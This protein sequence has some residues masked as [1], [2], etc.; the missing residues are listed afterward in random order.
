M[1]WHCAEA[2]NAREAARYAIAAAE[3]YAVHSAIQDA[4]EMLS[5]A[6]GYL[7]KQIDEVEG[8]ALKL[9]L[10]ALK[11]TITVAK[12]GVGSPEARELY[13]E[14]VEL[15][16]QHPGQGREQWFPLYWGWWFTAP[17]FATQRKRAHFILEEMSASNDPEI[18]L[19]ARHCAWA[20]NFNTGRH[21]ECLEHIEIGLS[22]YDNERASVSRVRYGGH[23]ARVCA[24]GERGLS[25]WFLGEPLKARHS[26][27]ACLGW[28]QEINHIGSISHA[29]DIAIMLGFYERD[30]AEVA[31][32]ARKMSNIAEAR[33]LPM[34]GAKSKIFSGWSRAIRGDLERGLTE[35]KKG[36]EMLNEIGTE[37][38]FPVYREM[39]AE[40]LCLLG[41]YESGTS[42][43]D[44]TI[45]RA[46]KAGHLFWMSQLHRRRALLHLAAGGAIDLAVADFHKAV[47]FAHEQRAIAI[48]RLAVADLARLGRSH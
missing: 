35:L 38:D 39:E 40:L 29:L 41:A 16:Q 25:L 22:L 24:L 23:D 34:L 10:L 18:C 48:E 27:N 21:H 47:D 20:T 36:V 31:N 12:N 7:G 28:A 3:D 11:G 26:V 44:T 15:N 42:L 4:D 9:R 6:A 43:L 8:W 2:G 46:S 33:D 17:D 13:Q 37:E 30:V 1:S 5:A 14:G 32:L 19:Q 45:L